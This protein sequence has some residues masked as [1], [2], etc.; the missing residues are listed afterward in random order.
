M[1]QIRKLSGPKSEDLRT[2][3]L[4]KLSHL[5]LTKNVSNK[6]FALTTNQQRDVQGIV[7]LDQPKKKEYKVEQRRKYYSIILFSATNY[8]E[9][10]KKREDAKYKEKHHIFTMNN[11]FINYHKQLAF[12]IYISK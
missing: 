3:P 6:I 11:Q 5:L 4:E 2:G 7:L 12:V 10:N 1:L 9:E 8:D